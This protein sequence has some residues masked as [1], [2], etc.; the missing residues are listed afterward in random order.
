MKVIH[1]SV[2]VTLLILVGFATNAQISP[3]QNVCPGTTILYTVS[4]IFAGKT[5]NWTVS[6]GIF[7]LG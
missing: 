6:G 5:L 3:N 2:L 1:V 7:G 4:G